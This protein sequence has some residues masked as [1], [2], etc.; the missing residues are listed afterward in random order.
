MTLDT[1]RPPIS[2]ELVRQHVERA[3]AELSKR[4]A[5]ALLV[6]RKS[7]ILAFCGVPLEPSD[8]LVCGLISRDGQ[9]AF[10]V[11]AFEASIASGL[12]AGSEL[13]AWEEFEDPYQATARAA[14]RLGVDTGT[15]ILDSHT[16]LGA[17]QRLAAAMPSATLVADTDLI[18]SI[19]MVK[20]AGELSA[21]RLAC[22]DTGKIYSLIEKRLRAGISEL[23]LRRDVI[24]QLE[25][26]GVTPFGDLIQGGES[27]SIPHQRTGTRVFREGDAVIVDFVAARGC[28]LGDMTRTF[29]VGEV[30]DEV[31][32]A[33][34]VV[35]DAQRAAISAIRP[36]VTCES[37]DSAARH[38]IE[39][40]G[41]GDFFVHRLGH[42]IGMDVHE[43][44]YFVQGNKTRLQPGMVLTVEPGVYVPGQFGIRIEDVIAVTAGSCDVLTKQIPTDFSPAFMS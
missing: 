1:I 41:L 10:V 44:P 39:Q 22:E 13:V 24:G 40:A 7:N 20:S 21:I 27:A 2:S 33:Y 3:A 4:G 38:V 29:A 31:R 36:G 9:V 43:A 26:L 5:S 17:Q 11:P 15:I 34:G 12:P 16:W 37:I 30:S 42:G 8:R 19:R 18:E 6:F 32:R 35:R 14:E 23:D 28:Y 25:K